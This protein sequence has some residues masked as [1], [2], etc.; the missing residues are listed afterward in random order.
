MWG[1][2]NIELPPTI[3]TWQLLAV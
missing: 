2:T 3:P 1:S